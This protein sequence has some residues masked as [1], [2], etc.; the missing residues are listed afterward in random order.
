MEM[1]RDAR[2]GC[3]AEV[4]PEVDAFGTVGR[5]ERGD[6]VRGISL[7]LLAFERLLRLRKQEK[8]QREV[9]Q[10]MLETYMAAMGML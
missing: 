6:N 10:E 5:L 8:R 1:T 7:K 9:E 2:S 3:L 4:G